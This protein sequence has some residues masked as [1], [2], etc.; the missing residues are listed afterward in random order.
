MFRKKAVLVYHIP[1]WFPSQ[2]PIDAAG[3]T[4]PGFE[5]FYP[6]ENGNGD[7]GSN[8]F[9]L[10]EEIALH[11]CVVR[12]TRRQWRKMN[13]QLLTEIER[14]LRNWEP[15]RAIA[16]TD[17]FYLNVQQLLANLRGTYLWQ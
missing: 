11:C 7:C 4:R 12:L 10:D 8:V 14:H 15:K 9:H 2:L 16:Q 1:M 17:N 5:C 6:L 13:K 3:N